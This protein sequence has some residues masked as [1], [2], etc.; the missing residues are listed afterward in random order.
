MSPYTRGP[1][2]LLLAPQGAH[3]N[4]GWQSS[5]STLMLRLLSQKKGCLEHLLLHIFKSVCLHAPSA[6]TMVIPGS[7][8]NQKVKLARWAASN[9]SCM[10]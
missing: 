5:M 8:T 10:S 3:G 7:K 1:L 2:R 6:L 9:L 4:L